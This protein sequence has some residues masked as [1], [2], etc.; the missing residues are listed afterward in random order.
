MHPRPSDGTAWRGA[1]R[2]GATQQKVQVRTKTCRLPANSLARSLSSCRN[3]FGSEL[4]YFL[5]DY[6]YLLRI[7]H[8]AGKQAGRQASRP[9]GRLSA[10]P[11][12]IT[13]RCVAPRWLCRKRAILKTINGWMGQQAHSRHKNLILLEYHRRACCS[14]NAFLS[15]FP[16]SFHSF[17]SSLF[18]P[19]RPP[20]PPSLSSLSFSHILSRRRL[21]LSM[22]LRYLSLFLPF[23]FSLSRIPNSS[24]YLHRTNRPSAPCRQCTFL[25][26]LQSHCRGRLKFKRRTSE[27]SIHVFANSQRTDLRSYAMIISLYLYVSSTRETR[28]IWLQKAIKHKTY[29]LA[30]VVIWHCKFCTKLNKCMIMIMINLHSYSCLLEN[31]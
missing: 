23:S 10:V 29:T 15:L 14:L 24:H 31:Q 18:P 9:A 11:Y 30:S 5:D 12:R 26:S 8:A 6:F 13:L 17:S 3:L 4:F 16:I 28:C 1:T 20:L 19:L 27:I 25:H 21:C 7:S 22:F 2:Y